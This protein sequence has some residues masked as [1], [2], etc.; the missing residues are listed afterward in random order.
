MAELSTES[1]PPADFGW[2][3]SDEHNDTGCIVLDAPSVAIS[4][5][6]LLLCLLG[7]VGN[8][9]ALWFLSCRIKRNPFTVYIL[10]LAVTDFIFLLCSAVYLTAHMVKYDWCIP[11]GF[12]FLLFSGAMLD[13]LTYSTS[14]YL[15]TAISTERCV[16]VLYPF[17]HRCRRPRHLSAII[18]ALLWALS[19][20]L[21]CPVGVFCVVLLHESCGT[22][23]LPMFVVNIMIFTP[24]MVVSSLTLTIKVRCTSQRHQPGKLY[25]IILLTV[26]FFFL[27]TLPHS[28]QLFLFYYRIFTY[29][30][31]FHLLA[32]AS[33]S[34]NP[35]IYLLVGS[36]RKRQICGS[37][38]VAL[39]RIF[40]EKTDCRE[41]GDAP[42]TDPMETAI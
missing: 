11:V 42:S 18:C 31:I 8:G 32:S 29:E 21:C 16:S 3:Y 37:V 17:W 24:I 27:F 14:L 28:V 5:I 26:L 7:M 6:T 22:F 10:N 38:K 25:I 36:Y 15:L 41:N 4:S 2:D 20:L 35:F 19:F 40:E 12:L 9:T 30:D 13:L 23:L 34:V 33:S 39:Q 1:L